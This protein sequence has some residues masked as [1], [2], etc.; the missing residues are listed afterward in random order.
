MWKVFINRAA[1]QQRL[2]RESVL[3]GSRSKSRAARGGCERGSAKAENTLSP[4]H[5]SLTGHRLLKPFTCIENEPCRHLENDLAIS[6]AAQKN[7][8]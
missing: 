5:C 8:G 7:T 3:H 6:V 1:A 2:R 4:F